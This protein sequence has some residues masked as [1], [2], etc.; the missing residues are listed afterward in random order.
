MSTVHLELS[1]KSGTLVHSLIDVC[2]FLVPP[3]PCQKGV[4]YRTF[5]AELTTAIFCPL[6]A[7]VEKKGRL[8]TRSEKSDKSSDC[9]GSNDE[10]HC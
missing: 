3:S 8:N 5:L 7:E 2:F 10:A 1:G 4:A 6:Q 9:I